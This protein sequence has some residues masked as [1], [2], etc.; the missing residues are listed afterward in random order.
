MGE[1]PPVRQPV[2][3]VVAGIERGEVREFL[4]LPRIRRAVAVGVRGRGVVVERQLGELRMRIAPV[5]RDVDAVVGVGGRVAEVELLHLVAR[6]P[7]HVRAR[8]ERRPCR[9]VVRALQRPCARVAAR[10]V[11]GRLERVGADDLR[12]RELHGGDHRGGVEHQQLRVAAVVECRVRTLRRA[13]R[14]VVAERHAGDDGV[15]VQRQLRQPHAG[16]VG[17]IR[18][19]AQPEARVGRRSAEREGLRLLARR[20][21]DPRPRIQ[22]RP[23]DAVIG[24]L[25]LPVAEVEGRG[26]RGGGDG[27]GSHRDRDV[28]RHLR[29]EE[30]RP[31]GGHVAGDEEARLVE[32]VERAI[33]VL[34]RIGL[35]GRGGYRRGVHPHR[36]RR[37][38]HIHAIREARRVLEILLLEERLRLQ[39]LRPR[40]RAVI[41]RDLREIDVRGIRPRRLRADADLRRRA[42]PEAEGEV[43]RVEVQR[44]VVKEALRRVALRADGLVQIR[45]AALLE[46]RQEL[47]P[48]GSRRIHPV[49]AARALE[50]HAVRAAAL[51]LEMHHIRVLAQHREDGDLIA[52]RAGQFLRRDP[53]GAH[54]VDARRIPRLHRAEVDRGLAVEDAG[55]EKH[56]LIHAAAHRVK[57][58]RRG[59]PPLV[60]QDRCGERRILDPIAIEIGGIEMQHEARIDD[61]LRMRTGAEC[62]HGKEGEETGGGSHTEGGRGRG[63]G[64]GGGGEGRDNDAGGMARRS[65]RELRNAECE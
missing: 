18:R 28:A 59:V 55:E 14:H 48:G 32:V 45:L 3:V 64:A 46:V 1:L 31:R 37:A 63:R 23:D 9:A 29:R 51:P 50:S 10:R 44:A 4:K 65:K 19:D 22:I 52:V 42:R 49:P 17:D 11:I 38:V 27:V 61:E 62:E 54:P 43:A 40:E 6:L 35:R 33:R 15:R 13:T 57:A 53:P 7:R 8:V 25:E 20:E 16:R 30:E 60:E 5:P 47:S 39:P 41:D 34:D 58:I 56:V 21:G 2:A 12:G 24:A 36:R 26:I